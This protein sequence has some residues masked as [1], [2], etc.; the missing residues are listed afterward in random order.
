M[1][2]LYFRPLGVSGMLA[3]VG[4]D[5]VLLIDTEQPVK[6]QSV[7][8]WHETIHLL[9]EIAGIPDFHHDEKKIEA[10]A[11]KLADAC[12]NIA[13]ELKTEF[14]TYEAFQKRYSAGPALQKLKTKPE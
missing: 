3:E 8:I 11:L 1:I 12:P 6:E 2:G 14:T 4:S 7:A 9:L 5:T 13:N 10:M